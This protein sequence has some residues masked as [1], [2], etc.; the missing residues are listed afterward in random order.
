MVQNSLQNHIRQRPQVYIPLLNL[1]MST[2]R[3]RSKHINS[4][5]PTNR[6][7][8]GTKEPMGRTVPTIHNQRVTRRLERLAGNS[9]RRT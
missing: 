6:W 2:P 4:L 1:T 9:H 3:D 5:S 7:P 8:L